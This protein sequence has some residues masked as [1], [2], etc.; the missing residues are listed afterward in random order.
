MVKLN[1]LSTNF[2]HDK[3]ST[4]NKPPIHIEWC[5][6]SYDNPISVYLDGDLFKGIQDHKVDGG[7]KKK[8][9]WV[10]ESRKFDGGAVDNI[11]NNLDDVLNTF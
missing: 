1:M 11:K 8:F 7:A 5:F 9:L 2:A 3:G 6:N 4:A 10:I